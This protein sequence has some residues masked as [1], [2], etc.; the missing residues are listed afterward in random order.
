MSNDVRY[1]SIAVHGGWGTG[2]SW[3]AD[4]APA[5]R[6][7]LDAEGGA[8]DTPSEKAGWDPTSGEPIP[9]A[10]SVV[11]DVTSWATIDH[12][13]RVL[14]S[15]DHPFESVVIDSLTE[16]QK[17]LKDRLSHGPD[18]VFDQQAWG[19]LLNNMEYLVRTLRD[20]TRPSA[21]KR[22]NVVIVTGTDDEMIPRKPMFQG[23]L[24]K[25]YAGFFDMVGYMTTTRNAD[26]E[27]VRQMQIQ[28]DDLA[29]A[30]CR[31]HKVAVAN[32]TGIITHPTVGEILTQVN[33]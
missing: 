33:D 10:D 15:G 5:P 3:F 30:K 8:Y 19:K 11:V 26:G 21:D 4:S 7:I 29:V 18:A 31:L 28:P 16:I 2:K 23:G 20:L 1:V 6:L 17:Q 22:V 13:M 27:L 32:P 24:R 14:V 12:V 9:N 25:S